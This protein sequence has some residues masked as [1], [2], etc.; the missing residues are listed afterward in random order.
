MISRGIFCRDLITLM[1]KRLENL[2]LE[3]SIQQ[4]IQL[5]WGISIV[6]TPTTTTKK[7][8]SG[9]K[10]EYKILRTITV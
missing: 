7:G 9:K 6:F 5:Y 10:L 1:M 4:E 2:P 8:A 3:H